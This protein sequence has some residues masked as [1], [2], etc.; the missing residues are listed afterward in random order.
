MDKADLELINFWAELN[1]NKK[2]TE[3]GVSY[4]VKAKISNG[5]LYV[6]VRIKQGNQNNGIFADF[7]GRLICDKYRCDV[8]FTYPLT[9]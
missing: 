8:R 1:A 2:A 3:L 6:L 4:Q 5:Y 7:I 9:I